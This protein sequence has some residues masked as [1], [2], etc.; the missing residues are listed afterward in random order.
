VGAAA[1]RAL[2]KWA[3]QIHHAVGEAER[4]RV[5]NDPHPRHDRGDLGGDASVRVESS[6]ESTAARARK[7]TAGAFSVAV[8]QSPE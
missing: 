3:A 8:D 1:L 7:M 2:W 4:L 6:I 5:G